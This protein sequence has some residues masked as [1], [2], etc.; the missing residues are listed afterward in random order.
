M[1]EIDPKKRATMAEVLEDPW[2]SGTVIC[3]QE[4]QG[5]IIRAQGHAHTLEPPAS[6]PAPS[7]SK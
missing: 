7:K 1:L 2:I 4:D 5:L 6:T 3:R